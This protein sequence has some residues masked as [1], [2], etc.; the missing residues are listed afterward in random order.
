MKI[1]LFQLMLVKSKN[2]IVNRG[3][4][5]SPFIFSSNCHAVVQMR[6]E[7]GKNE[8]YGYIV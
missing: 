7:K 3:G 2:K 1:Q 8:E 6:D 5:K 4:V